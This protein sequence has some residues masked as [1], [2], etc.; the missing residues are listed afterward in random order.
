VYD[1]VTT[2]TVGETLD[3]MLGAGFFDEIVNYLTDVVDDEVGVVVDDL[4]DALEL[5]GV[6]IEDVYDMINLL[7][8]ME[9]AGEDVRDYID[10]YIDK[11]ICDLLDEMMEVEESVDYEE[12]IMQ[13]ALEIKQMPVMELLSMLFENNGGGNVEQGG[14]SSTK[15]GYGEDYEEDFNGGYYPPENGGQGDKEDIVIKPTYPEGDYGEGKEEIMIPEKPRKEGEAAD[16]V[17]EMIVQIVTVLKKNSLSFDTTKTGEVL[18]FSAKLVDFGALG[19][20]ED[21]IED[22]KQEVIDKDYDGY[23]TNYINVNGTITLKTNGSFEGSFDNLADM[24]DE[25]ANVIDGFIEKVVAGEIEFEYDDDAPYVDVEDGEVFADVWVGKTYS[26]EE[27]TY[28]GKPATKITAYGEVKML[29]SEYQN[30]AVISD[31]LNWVSYD[32]AGRGYYETEI[33]VWVDEN[34]KYLGVEIPEY[35]EF[36]SFSSVLDFYYNTATGEYAPDNHDGDGMHNYELVE[37]QEAE[38]CVGQGYYKYACTHCGNERISYYKNG[39]EEIRRFVLSEGS[40]TCEDGIDVVYS[41]MRCGEELDRSHYGNYHETWEEETVVATTDC[42]AIY[43]V[44]YRCACGE[45]D[46]VGHVYGACEFDYVETTH[47]E[48]TDTKYNHYID[49]YRCAVTAC[50]YTYTIEN[51]YKDEGCYEYRYR[52]YKYG[53]K[54]GSSKVDYTYTDKDEWN[55]HHLGWKDERSQDGSGLWTVHTYCT[56]CGTES[57]YYQARYNERGYTTYYK[58]LM[59]GSREEWE[60]SYEDNSYE[61][62]NYYYDYV[63]EYGWRRVYNGCEY[64]QYDLNWNFEYE[65]DMHWWTGSW[66]YSDSC[67]QYQFEG[68][69]Y[70]CY[71]CGEDRSEGVYNPPKDHYYVYNEDLGLYVCETCGMQNVTGA[72]AAFVIEDLSFT[73]EFG[74]YAIGYYNKEW[75]DYEVKVVANY[76]MENDEYLS[77]VGVTDL[78][79]HANSGIVTINMETLELAIESLEAKGISVETISVVMQYYDSYT[80]TWLD[81]VVTFD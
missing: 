33:T 76:G 44:R 42:G 34:G 78:T 58:N 19:S 69:Y 32:V 30:I 51:Y 47:L 24:G 1:I 64:V 37:K 73:G 16:P 70:Y 63:G 27:V 54:E 81:C 21:A 43:M 11:D 61:W 3:L 7:S 59:K 13:Y 46:K 2:K 14:S 68:K 56:A 80:D 49:T 57:S 10:E 29:A 40:V 55:S 62:Q 45:Y 52:I 53:V 35:A 6:D 22:A 20:L 8:G 15:P 75:R 79:T 5:C 36:D 77:G 48:G 38:G 72:D 25:F 26:S 17:Y 23:G 31:C 66:H 9:E 41:C 39:H 60:A 71:Y 67:T 4:T 74:C 65:G 28:G 12:M 18:S 50:A